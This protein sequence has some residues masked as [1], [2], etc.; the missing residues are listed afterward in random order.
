M[1][2]PL[3]ELREQGFSSL[4]WELLDDPRCLVYS[5]PRKDRFGE[6]LKG[7]LRFYAAEDK[8]EYVEVK[9]AE[10]E[11]KQGEKGNSYLIVSPG[12]IKAWLQQALEQLDGTQFSIKEVGEGIQFGEIKAANF[13]K[14]H[15]YLCGPLALANR[16]QRLGRGGLGVQRIVLIG[17]EGELVR[18]EWGNYSYVV[19]RLAEFARLRPPLV[20]LLSHPHP[21]RVVQWL[22][23]LSLEPAMVYHRRMYLDLQQATQAAF[24]TREDLLEHVEQLGVKQYCIYSLPPTKAAFLF[25]SN[26]DRMKQQF[27]VE[28][29]K[30]LRQVSFYV[31]TEGILKTGALVC[32][33]HKLGEDERWE[34]LTPRVKLLKDDPKYWRNSKTFTKCRVDFSALKIVLEEGETYAVLLEGV[35]I[36]QSEHGT[37]ICVGETPLPRQ[38]ESGKLSRDG[39][40]SW[41]SGGKPFL[42]AEEHLDFNESPENEMDAIYVHCHRFV[43][44]A[45][46]ARVAAFLGIGGE[47]ILA[48]F[49]G[50]QVLIGRQFDL[51]PLL[52]DW[53][54]ER[55]L[56]FVLGLFRKPRT[57][58]QF[59]QS[60]KKAYPY[61]VL[62]Q[63][64]RE[65]PDEPYVHEKEEFLERVG[66]Q[67]ERAEALDLI[68]RCMTT[69][70]AYLNTV[71]VQDVTSEARREGEMTHEHLGRTLAEGAEG[72]TQ[73]QRRSG[74]VA[75]SR[76]GRASGYFKCTKV[77]ER[78]AMD[79][80]PSEHYVELFTRLKDPELS[81]KQKK[82][83]VE[84]L[85]HD[86]WE[87]ADPLASSQ[88]PAKVVSI[89]QQA[90][91]SLRDTV[92]VYK[93]CHL[94]GPDHRIPTFEELFGDDLR[95][96]KET[97]PSR[98]GKRRIYFKTTLRKITEYL[99]GF[100]T[101]PVPK[102][103]PKIDSR[104]I[105]WYQ[106]L[107]Q[108][109][110]VPVRSVNHL[111]NLYFEKVQRKEGAPKVARRRGKAGTVQTRDDSEV[112]QGNWVQC[113]LLMQLT[114]IPRGMLQVVQACRLAMRSVGCGRPLLV[115][116]CRLLAGG[117][118]MPLE[119][120]EQAC[121]QCGMYW[122][123]DRSCAGWYNLKEEGENFLPATVFQVMRR[124]TYGVVTPNS[125]ACKW[126]IPREQGRLL[127]MKAFVQVGKLGPEGRIEGWGCPRPECD[128]LMD[129]KPKVGRVVICPICEVRYK[130]QID[131]QVRE[132]VDFVTEI[133]RLVRHYSSLEPVL[134][135]SAPQEVDF[136]YVTWDCQ[137]RIRGDHLVVEYPSGHSEEFP[138][139]N[140]YVMV[141]TD[142]ELATVLET[143]GVPMRFLRFNP[144]RHPVVS[145]Q[146]VKAL[147]N[148]TQF[149]TLRRK[150]E[151]GL[152]LSYIV[153]TLEM[154][155]G[156]EELREEANEILKEQLWILQQFVKHQK[157]S[158]GAF[159]ACEGR[160]ARV[161]ETTIREALHRKRPREQIVR[162]G[163]GR[164]FGRKGDRLYYQ[165]TR[166]AAGKTKLDA[167]QNRASKLLRNKLR[168]S[169]A[170]IEYES[171]WFGYKTIELFTHKVHDSP[172]IAGHLDLE[173][174]SQRLLGNWVIFAFLARELT[175]EHF[176]EYRSPQG[177]PRCAPTPWG[178]RTLETL[179]ST[180]LEGEIWYQGGVHSL[181]EAHAMHVKHLLEC[182]A[183]DQPGQYH[184][185]IPIPTQVQ[186]IEPIE[187]LR[188]LLIELP[189]QLGL[190]HKRVVDIPQ[191]TVGQV[192]REL[193]D[194]LRPLET[195]FKGEK[196]SIKS[197]PSTIH[198]I[199]G[200]R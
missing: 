61:F 136:V 111:L 68:Q 86:R 20:F 198:T 108:E 129:R 147:E 182:I 186:N 131:G 102:K 149:E 118:R 152:L 64:A 154:Q 93:T 105:L 31:R 24:H 120:E 134:P 194:V 100:I 65:E 60:V 7:L 193:S 128:G 21:T 162:E 38:G 195:E 150:Y 67:F 26:Q 12:Y 184:P 165:P 121:G 37:G 161:M 114:P 19:T 11:F 187:K 119:S 4:A 133:R 70:K 83:L 81:E 200:R 53:Y 123:G 110:A 48:N 50:D 17:F 56:D 173:E 158:L 163:I 140:V 175:T 77:G 171:L 47:L 124:A 169:N 180:F 170:E 1:E 71:S 2:D 41:W 92:W 63:K 29:S 160:L 139:I 151:W 8:R 117:L 45:E 146:L 138:L 87:V 191:L 75:E 55:G 197:V 142:A 112:A 190:W 76:K 153:A 23:F 32:S 3:E 106:R 85:A 168:V 39:G 59:H 73:T 109:I 179:V 35:D 5:D 172:S 130:G 113:R 157:F 177:F 164:T 176:Q 96:D 132:Q 189:K 148:C 15:V 58:K 33:V 34:C 192:L 84:Q 52:D 22:D 95:E 66:F 99:Y 28:Q 144:P 72:G 126:F 145:I 42:E 137:G 89:G 6:L 80:R 27:R 141:Q 91:L 107:A 115:L 196:T 10:G 51:C 43:S 143:R 88:R 36:L 13:E 174:P 104:R 122:R 90:R 30:N 74:T 183:K 125:A 155:Q 185:F 78:I 69:E 79:Y 16:L 49:K 199:S 94:H 135:E 103:G 40:R 127:P 116:E 188:Q 159:L 14:T 166:A 167:A 82:E 181:A 18:K 98:Q 57:R 62:T 156:L 9:T 54:M 101:S 25:R 44:G 46:L 178:S 97:V